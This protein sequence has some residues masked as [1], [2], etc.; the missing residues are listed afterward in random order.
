MKYGK[1]ERK[2][3][4]GITDHVCTSNKRNFP[5]QIG[6]P[7]QIPVDNID[8]LIT[9]V[10]NH[11]EFSNAYGSLFSKWQ[12][13]HST[14]D[15]IY[16][17]I[18]S[19]KLIYAYKEMRRVNNYFVEYF[20]YEPRINFTANKG[21]AIYC[22]YP[23][24]KIEFMKGYGFIIHLMAILKLKHLDLKVSRDSKRITRLPYSLNFNTIKAGNDLKLCVPI[25]P[26]WSLHQIITES[27]NCK[28][29]QDIIIEPNEEIFKIINSIK[30]PKYKPP[31]EPQRNVYK[32]NDD[33]INSI[34]NNGNLFTDGRH[35][36]LCKI[37]IPFMVLENNTDDEIIQTC[38]E[39]LT[40]SRKNI[41][42]YIIFIKYHIKRNRERRY[43]PITIGELLT[44][45]IDIFQHMK[46]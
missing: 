9:E 19:Y 24:Q 23:E 8:E 2:I 12:I 35:R 10:M 7:R 1:I 32:T 38:S 46:E 36:I 13:Q 28:F 41:Q 22:D 18:D 27:K 25:N 6:F 3:I 42:E 37:I 26:S 20:D 34:V 15:K 16:L 45:N 39:F 31:V 5:R 29:E 14:F 30:L 17:D 21:F 44:E 43:K 40:N 4:N 11:I 33:Q